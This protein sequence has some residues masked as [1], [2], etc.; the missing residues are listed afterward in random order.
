LGA[1][2]D[3]VIQVVDEL[4]RGLDEAR[5]VKRSVAKKL[6][7]L[8]LKQ[9]AQEAK[10]IKNLMLKLNEEAGLDEEYHILFGEA[11]T[12]LYPN[13]IY[14]GLAVVNGRVKVLVFSGSE[15][16]KSGVNAGLLAKA[17]SKQ[18]G[19]SGG[20]DARF[21]QGGGAVDKAKEISAKVEEIVKEMLGE[22]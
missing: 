16:V 11:A 5:R 17:L 20:G 14:V 9:I 13:L 2:E 22:E 21:G 19:G 15:A 7:N 6:V 8:E 4:K 12:S 18:M 3:K 10:P 1:Q